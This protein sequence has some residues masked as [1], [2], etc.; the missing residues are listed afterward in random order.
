MYKIVSQ[1]KFLRSRLR[2]YVNVTAS[3]LYYNAHN[4]SHIHYAS[5]VWYGYSKIH[6]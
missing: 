4:L 3:K 1:N 2:N 5:I 6:L